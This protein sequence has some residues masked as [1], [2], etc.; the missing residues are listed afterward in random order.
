V[1]AHGRNTTQ[2]G[3]MGELVKE[4]S[5]QTSELVRQ[6]VELAKVELTE[7]GKKAGVGAGMFGTAGVLGLFGLALLTAALVIG[8]AGLMEDWVAAVIVGVVYLVAAGVAAL[9]GRDKVREAGPMV[10]EQTVETVKEDVQ[11]AK[12]QA[13]S[14]RR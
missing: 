9:Q 6:E 4:L 10:P 1:E 12:N 5:R 3:S 11:W 2:D 7:K 14:A 13:S 8:L